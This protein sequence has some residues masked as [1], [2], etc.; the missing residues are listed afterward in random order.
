MKYLGVSLWVMLFIFAGCASE[1]EKAAKKFR[2]MAKACRENNTEVVVK[3]LEEAI[4]PNPEYYG[5]ADN[6][7]E[8]EYFA[9][10]T[11]APIASAAENGNYELAKI[12]LE[13]GAN[14]NS[15]C[16][17]CV[18]AL[19]EAILKGH[20]KI[21]ELLLANGADP[22]MPYE[23]GVETLGLAEQQGNARIVKIIREYIEQH[24]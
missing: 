7:S 21:V 6:G 19:H 2:A 1:N 8:A 5:L 10:I 3:F 13:H 16:C 24:P 4:N 20:E 14:P 15:C 11:V 22:T 17:T 18:T 12:L 23:N 9:Q